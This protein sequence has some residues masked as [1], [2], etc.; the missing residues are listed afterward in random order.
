MKKK[1]DK[2]EQAPTRD[3][4]DNME[5]LKRITE[6][7]SSYPDYDP[8]YSHSDGDIIIALNPNIKRKRK[9]TQ[10][11]TDAIKFMMNEKHPVRTG[12]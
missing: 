7:V 1:N 9:T 6:L 11:L 2:I 12:K 5:L 4:D 3:V 8:P 10:N